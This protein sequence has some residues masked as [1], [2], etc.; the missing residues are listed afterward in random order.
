MEK[1]VEIPIILGRL[2]LA[3][4]RA[5]INVQDGKLTFTVNDEEVTF[6]IYKSLKHPKEVN[7]VLKYKILNIIMQI[8][9]CLVVLPSLTWS[10]SYFV[11]FFSDLIFFFSKK[12]SR[13]LSQIGTL[14][15]CH[16]SYTVL[17]RSR[18]RCNTTSIEDMW[19]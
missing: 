8:M 7:G 13:S 5:L 17:Q 16:C 10:C 15:V 12:F 14:V 9:I 11:V 1:D 2:F 19:K 3:N 18:S 4:G 6:N